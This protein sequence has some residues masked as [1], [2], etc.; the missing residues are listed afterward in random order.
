MSIVDVFYLG[1]PLAFLSGVGIAHP[2]YTEPA[3]TGWLRTWPGGFLTPCGLN[4]VGSPGED[5][6]EAL[7][8]HGRVAGIP[9]RDVRWGGEWRD[10]DYFLYVEG[11]VRQVSVFGE[12]L[13]LRRRVSMWMTGSRFW[14]EDIVENHAFTPVPHM[15]LQHFNLGFP[16]VDATTRLEMPQHTTEPR[17]EIA[18]LGAS[19]Y[20]I[21]EEPQAG[22]QEQV[23]YHHLHADEAGQVQVR[24]VN[25]NFNHGQGLG[26]YWRYN[27]ADYPRFVQWKM[28][29]EGLYVVGI[30]P[31]NCYVSGRSEERQ[32]GTLQ[33]LAPEEIR[34]YRMEVG[35]FS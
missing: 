23:F 5:D 2:A 28:M 26:V 3:G 10:D 12:D 14:I 6:G 18:N 24:L 4:Q 32:N 13:S 7:G 34:Q 31:S 8:L 17:D 11:T 20:N 21:F 9:A 25:P 27:L 1:V 30:E 16:L 15:F 29:G 22:Y 35:F 19:R 33:M